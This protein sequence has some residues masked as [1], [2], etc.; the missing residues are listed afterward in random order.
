MGLFFFFLFIW[1]SFHWF[2]N[3]DCANLSNTLDS[4][5]Y[6][7]LHHNWLYSMPPLDEFCNISSKTSKFWSFLL[8]NF[9]FSDLKEQQLSNLL[10][11][12]DTQNFH[13]WKD[14]KRSYYHWFLFVLRVQYCQAS[15]PT[16]YS[17]E[18]S[19]LF[20]RMESVHTASQ[21]AWCSTFGCMGHSWLLPPCQFYALNFPW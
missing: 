13:Y 12:W 6:F 8:K 17:V 15:E 16:A 2:G 1:S 19:S 18:Q 11:F 14:Q 3:Q 4:F 7:S 20:I 5:P 10:W 21:P 9:F